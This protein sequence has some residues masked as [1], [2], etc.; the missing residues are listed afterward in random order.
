[1][2]KTERNARARTGSRSLNLCPNTPS[3]QV[4]TA[5]MICVKTSCLSICL[6][7]LNQKRL[8]DTPFDLCVLHNQSNFN[9]MTTNAC[10]VT[11]SKVHKYV[12]YS[13]RSCTLVSRFFDHTKFTLQ[14]SLDQGRFFC[15]LKKHGVTGEHR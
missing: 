7:S 10:Y 2:D 15:H 9:C 14:L 4:A 6:F 1:M 3:Q 5:Y 12:A 8:Q 11:C 13:S